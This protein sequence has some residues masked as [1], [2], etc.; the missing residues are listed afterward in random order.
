MK[1]TVAQA[2]CLYFEEHWSTNDIAN[3]FGV[4]Q[5]TV[6]RNLQA[7]GYKLRTNSESQTLRNADRDL[8]I[9]EIV[10][11]YFD[12]GLSARETGERLGISDCCV[13]TRLR[14]AGYKPRKGHGGVSHEP[15]AH[16][17]T[18]NRCASGK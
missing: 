1:F 10:E 9:D 14:R 15:E 7:A 8:M 13:L 4:G 17:K 16:S 6:R 5:G 2:A 12:E 18:A 3:M 11:L